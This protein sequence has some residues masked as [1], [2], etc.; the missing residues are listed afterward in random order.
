MA[1]PSAL[2][3]YAREVQRLVSDINA[4]I[5]ALLGRLQESRAASPE[6]GQLQTPSTVDGGQGEVEE[7]GVVVGT[8][9]APVQP[10]ADEGAEEGGDERQ[11][12]CQ[13]SGCM[14]Q[15]WLGLQQWVPALAVVGMLCGS[16][17]GALFATGLGLQNPVFV[18]LGAAV[19]A[20]YIGALGAIIGGYVEKWRR[21]N[22]E[23]LRQYTNGEA[24]A[25]LELIDVRDF[26]TPLSPAKA[27]EIY[28]KEREREDMLAYRDGKMNNFLAVTGITL[29]LFM[30]FV[31]N[32][33]LRI[34]SWGSHHEA[35]T[36]GSN[37]TATTVLDVTVTP[38]TQAVTFN[39]A[40]FAVL[41]VFGLVL[42]IQTLCSLMFRLSSLVNWLTSPQDRV[43]PWVSML[44]GLVVASQVEAERQLRMEW[45]SR[46][47][48]SHLR[49]APSAAA[50]N[51]C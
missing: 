17:V 34:K 37:G 3:N 36:S 40:G 39:P 42:V 25:Q 24:S 35:T 26:D 19:G 28:D 21:D 7:K 22:V 51:A 18:L 38:P 31:I 33:D 47:V 45:F 6:L 43:N 10:P 49:E 20:Y 32:S 48:K 14:H 8:F 27:A 13:T 46:K 4:E 16:I 11:S 1:D 5:A 9:P 2:V 41:V 23:T 15:T 12:C 44:P 30:I 29:M 50:P